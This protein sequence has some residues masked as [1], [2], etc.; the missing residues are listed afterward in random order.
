MSSSNL[1][2]TV[3]AFSHLFQNAAVAR[4]YVH[5][6]MTEEDINELAA[7]LFF[8]DADYKYAINKRAIDNVFEAYRFATEKLLTS[9]LKENT[10]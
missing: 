8:V 6:G 5:Y 7:H 1:E 10:K 9:L 4:G 3:E 2:E